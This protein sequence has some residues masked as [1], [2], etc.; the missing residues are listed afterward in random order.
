MMQQ[1]RFPLGISVLTIIVVL[2]LIPMVIRY[3]YGLGAISNMSDGRPWGLWIS[4]D[5]YCG[6]ALAAGGFT[7][8]GWVY[9]FHREKYHAVARPAILTAF[10]GYTLVI[11]SLLVDLGQP[12]YIWH[13]I[14]YWNIHSPLFEVSICVM[15]YTAVL[16]LEFSPVVFEAL[17]KS[18]LPVIRRIKWHIPL[19]V[20]RTIQIPLVIAGIVL[21]TLHQS[22]LG[23]LLLLMPTTL[24][25]LWYSPILPIMFLITAVAV[26]PAMVI[27]ETTL[28]TKAFGH[29]LPLDVL[30]GLSRGLP[31]ILGFYLLLKL[32]ELIVAGE[33]GLI[34]TAYPQNLLWWGEIIIGVVLPVILLSMPRIRGSR[35]GV[36]CGA[37]LV[38]LGLIFNR[39]NV[40]MLALTMRPGFS[41]V[42]HWME[43][44]ISGALVADAMLVIWLAYRL[45]PMVHHEKATE[46][47]NNAVIN[48]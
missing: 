34:F 1:R 44:A 35:N 17:G 13:G 36:F 40:S 21:S 7:L 46:T 2:G 18:N 45:L 15:T 22:S 6:V 23:S 43:I 47:T 30:S 25:P 29:K 11:L 3:I 16:A 5:L 14:I 8:A 31:Y 27:F 26:G 32:V 37:L 24:H 12:W 9:V 28:S 48:A 33:I 20:I 4:F 38:V 39:F 19:R 42:P 41:Y 10:L